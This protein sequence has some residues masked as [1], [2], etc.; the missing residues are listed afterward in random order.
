MIGFLVGLVAMPVI[1]GIALTIVGAWLAF[2]GWC[3]RD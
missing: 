3:D 2:Q 1:G